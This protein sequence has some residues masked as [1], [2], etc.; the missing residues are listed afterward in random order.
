MESVQP[1][2]RA[3]PGEMMAMVLHRAGEPL[4]RSTIARPDPKP[5]EVLLKVSACGVC[6]TDLHIVDGELTQSDLPLVPG[7]EIVGKVCAV[8]VGVDSALVGQRLGVPWMGGAC[9]HCRYCKEGRENLCDN[10][11]F[12]GYTVDGG[13]AEY[14][15]ARADFCVRLPPLYNDIQA[16]PLLCAG[17]I[18]YRALKAA[19]QGKVLGIYGF[20]A[21]AHIVAQVAR[22]QGWTVM[23]FTRPGDTKTQNFART[24]GASWAGPSD[25][26]SPAELDAAI[27]F[28]PDGAL[29]PIALASVR[30]G[31][32]IVCA[33]IHMSD[34]P[35]FRYS[36][37]WSERELVSVANL[38]RLDAQEFMTLAGSCRLA[39]ASTAYPLDQ[40]NRALDDLGSGR[41]EGAAV[42]VPQ[43][44]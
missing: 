10:P 24:L 33:G 43:G 22:N 8:G 37:L 19:G 40:A 17:L 23:A 29:V 42:L 14:V 7:H 1:L 3:K 13:Y 5:G 30:K 12:T 36:L 41:L 2:L 39:I 31:G 18:G 16:A 27:I 15:C 35:S 38:T 26:Q 9:G 4:Q 21:A 44:A 32:R 34:I 25:R 11:E 20:G 28:A 6:R